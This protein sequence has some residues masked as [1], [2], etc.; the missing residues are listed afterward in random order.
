MQNTKPKRDR[1]WIF[2][3]YPDSAPQ[4]WE[5]IIT[6]IGAEWGHSPLHD[7][8]ENEYGG[9][10]KPHYHC[11]IKFKSLKS[12]RQMLSL[13]GQLHAP[14][15]K[16]CESVVGKVRYWLHLDNPEKYQYKKEDIKAFCGFDVKEVLKPSK[17]QQTAMMREIRKYI[18]DNNILELKQFMDYADKECPQW[19][20]VINRFQ[21]QIR[22]YINSSRYSSNY[23][24]NKHYQDLALVRRFIRNNDITDMEDVYAF[25]DEEK[26]QL[27]Y[28]MDAHYLE[29]KDCLTSVQCRTARPKD[30]TPETRSLVQQ[31]LP[32]ALTSFRDPIALEEYYDRL[33]SEPIY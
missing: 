13:T 27:A 3:V 12:Y 4:N 25:L 29:I 21:F 14:N 28:L 30:V 20:Y 1:K 2:I 26:P 23:R 24:Q 10:K 19:G 7:K 18:R 15:P 32:K 31:Q 22:D 16:P 6:D 5:D 11:L 17:T 33:D 9:V 8:D